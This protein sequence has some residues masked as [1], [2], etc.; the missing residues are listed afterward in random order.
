MIVCCCFSCVQLTNEKLLCCS[1]K[2]DMIQI[3]FDHI[4]SV[5]TVTVVFTW[6]IV[7]EDQHVTKALVLIGHSQLAESLSVRNFEV[8][9]ITGTIINSSNSDDELLILEKNKILNLIWLRTFFILLKPKCS[10]LHC[11][12]IYIILYYYE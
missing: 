1:S 6:L 7:S 9:A 5:A 11:I 8:D 12:Y 2:L 3:V 10:F 4:T